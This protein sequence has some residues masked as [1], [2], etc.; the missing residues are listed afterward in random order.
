MES[1]FLWVLLSGF[2]TQAT[3]CPVAAYSSESQ[4]GLSLRLGLDSGCHLSSKTS[5]GQRHP[6]RRKRYRLGGDPPSPLDLPVSVW[7]PRCP[8]F[9]DCHQ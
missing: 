6:G 2:V 3:F 5:W 9:P 4:F 1:F 8:L 7:S